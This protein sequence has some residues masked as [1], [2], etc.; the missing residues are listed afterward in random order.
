VNADAVLRLHGFSRSTASYRVRIALTLKRLTYD[1]VS[2]SLRN[3]DQRRPDYLEINPQGLVPAL[4]IDGVTLTQSLAICEYLDET[5][6]TPP[7]LPHD[8]VMRA[9][10]RA[11][12]Q[13]IACDVHPLQNLKIL[14]RLKACGL[15]DAAVNAWAGQT[16]EEGLDAC[17]QLLPETSHPFCFGDTPGLADICLVPQLV[18]ARRFGVDRRWPR[19]LKIEQTCLR[20][21]AF[22]TTSPAAL[23]AKQDQGLVA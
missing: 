3:G 6:P 10:V 20:Q 4:E 11:F 16:I 5:I 1:T 13:V 2:Y 12:A 19:L 14:G 21:A 7:L 8:P 15:D 23:E 17:N 9:K 18:N 22:A